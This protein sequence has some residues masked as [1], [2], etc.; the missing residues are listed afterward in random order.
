M[1][2]HGLSSSSADTEDYPALVTMADNVRA[3]HAL[4]EH[5]ELVAERITRYTSR[6]GPRTSSRAPTAG[7]APASTA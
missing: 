4:I 7:S 6:L 1:F 3:Q 5:P 2:P